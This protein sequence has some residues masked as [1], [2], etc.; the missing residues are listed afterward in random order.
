[1]AAGRAAGDADEVRVGA[2]L[3]GVLAHPGDRPLDVDHVLGKGRPR[4]QP[5]VDVE[6]DPAAGGEVVEQRDALLDAAADDPAA[7]VD[8][9]DR[10]ARPRRRLLGRH[11]RRRGAAPDRHSARTRSPRRRRTPRGHSI[12]GGKSDVA[13]RKAR[14]DRRSARSRSRRAPRAV[15]SAA[16][17]ALDGEARQRRARRAR[18]AHHDDAE[19]RFEG[20]ES[21][22]SA[23]AITPKAPNAH[24]NSRTAEPAIQR[25]SRTCIANGTRRPDRLAKQSEHRGTQ[26]APSG[27]VACD[28]AVAVDEDLAR[29]AQRSGCRRARVAP[30]TVPR[31]RR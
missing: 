7:A 17:Q 27:R 28:D 29:A 15:V 6:A 8:L 19:R 18:A 1:M 4:A 16:P 10:R 2:V 11:R 14:R 24:G 5:V 26:G 20:A 25:Q 12:S 30:A 21:T 31:G 23:I 3:G 13:E 22:S 9:D